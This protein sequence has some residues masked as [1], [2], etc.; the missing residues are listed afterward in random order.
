M[1]GPTASGK[2]AIAI[3]LAQKFNGVIVSADSR[4]VYR[5]MDI[6]T[7]K[8]SKK[9]LK[10]TNHHLID[11]KN[12]DQEYSVAEF[13]KDAI[14]E[15]NK[16]FKAGKLPILIGGTGL[17]VDAVVKN[18]DIPEV[19]ENKKLRARLEKE[20]KTKGLDFVFKKL[21]E[22][23]PEAAYI[24]DP[25]NPRRI[26]RALEVA[27]ITGKPFTAQRKTGKPLFDALQIGIRQSPEVLK[28]RI[29]K[30][31]E[32]MVRDGLVLEVKKLIKKYGAKQKAF[33]AIGYREVIDYLNSKIT[34]A[35]AISFINKNT[36]H[37]ARRQMTWFKKNKEIRWIHGEAQAIKIV[38][39]FIYQEG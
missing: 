7:A 21:V 33:D 17:Y 3:K 22:I 24:V 25:K 12:P 18:L 16:I 5:G 1:V 28:K 19:K 31:T 35:E 11:I 39:K 13:K 29:E 23:D 14:A 26:I 9:E 4:Q 34:L 20:I 15:I 37:Y 2:S 38:Q 10:Y 6:G 30:R 32:Q 27:L 36:W 8:P